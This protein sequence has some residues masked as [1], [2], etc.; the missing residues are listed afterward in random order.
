MFATQPVRWIRPFAAVLLLAVLSG[1]AKVPLVGGKPAADMTITA[2]PDCNNC[3]RSGAFPL[4]LRVLQLKD[5]TPLARTTLPQL[6]DHEA[7]V[8]G[9]AMIGKPADQ[10]LDPGKQIPLKMELDPATRA[11]V[12]E[13]NFCKTQGTCWYVLKSLKRGQSLKLRVA[14]HSTCLE[15]TPK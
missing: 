9:E 12:V 6:W 8:L 14:A 15:E 5:A 7:E 13:G 1:C 11:V 2:A 3:G 10:I 4:T